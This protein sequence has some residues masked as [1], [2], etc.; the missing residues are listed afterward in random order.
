[1]G[2]NNASMKA[3][4]GQST[5]PSPVPTQGFAATNIVGTAVPKVGSQPARPNY[6]GN[7]GDAVHQYH[8]IGIAVFII[9]AGFLLHWFNFEV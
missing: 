3:M 7:V 2:N 4:M 6:V 1:M 8:V 5:S 9:V